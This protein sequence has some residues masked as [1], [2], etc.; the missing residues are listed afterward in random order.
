MAR[1]IILP[2]LGMA[3]DTGKIVRWLK[4]AGEPVKK[5]EPVVEIET[6]KATVE[7]ESPMSGFLS[8]ITG[9]EGEDI[10]VGQVIA[11][12]ADSAAPLQK[13]S[14]GNNEAFGEI[15][16]TKR[17]TGLEA[18]EVPAYNTD[19]QNGERRLQGIQASPLATRIATEH[20]VD[21]TQIRSSGKRIQKADVLD[22]LQQ[23]ERASV[24]SAQPRLLP[25]SPKARRLAN[26]Q[27]IDLS[28]LA[29]SGPQGAAL[30]SDVLN[31]PRL[32]VT[33][34]TP[35]LSV[36]E[37]AVSPANTSPT[38][39]VST[40]W[41]I[42][43]ERT[44]QSWTTVPHFFLVREVNASRLIAWRESALK[45][46]GDKV[47][48]TDLLVKA[49]AMA[50]RNHPNLNAAWR[51]NRINWNVEINVGLAVAVEQGLIVP[52]IHRA[53]TLGVREIAARRQE[54]VARA[55]SGNLR[56]DDLAGGTFTL[57]NLG[58]YGVDAFNA[59]I[60]QPQAAILAVGRIA[61][62]VVPLNGQPAVQPMMTFS[63][64]CDHRVV[65]GARGAQ[66][67]AWLAEQVEEPLGLL[68]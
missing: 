62:R 14:N 5:G 41:R 16:V 37:V 1:E 44:T 8:N 11:I 22:Y 13:V 60:N 28:T 9:A 20:N 45:R 50:L 21:L 12:V 15:P 3:Q 29:G 33:P 39:E 40:I 30:V 36:V 59:I 34:A 4:A 32:P 35:E 54:L 10:P 42:M 24:S 17:T 48:Y 19:V 7:I 6:D 55:M 2:A 56:P 47:T 53:D 64:S 57:S 52:V 68:N 51:D 66:F 26:E 65:D 49:A 31:A 23:Q 61:D 46:T 25:A 43:A 67:L 38:S 27:G 63:L 18:V 58:M